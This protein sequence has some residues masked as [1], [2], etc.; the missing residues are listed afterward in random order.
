LEDENKKSPP[1]NRSSQRGRFEQ[2][3]LTFQLDII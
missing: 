1:E 2:C 3:S